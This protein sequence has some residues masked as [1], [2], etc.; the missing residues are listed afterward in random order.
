MLTRFKR[1][2]ELIINNKK[3][4]NKA[5]HIMLFWLLVIVCALLIVPVAISTLRIGY[6]SNV[7]AYLTLF[8]V[9]AL[10]LVLLSLG[11]CKQRPVLGL[12]FGFGMVF[13]LNIYLSVIIS[14]TIEP[15]LYLGHFVLFPYVL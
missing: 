11:K 12:Y 3:D 6:V 1:I 13:I 15:Q 8:L 7:P 9:Y 5:N 14:P 4:V 2:K 10:M